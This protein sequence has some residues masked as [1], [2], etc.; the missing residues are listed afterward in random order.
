M[1]FLIP[2]MLRV[3]A[4]HNLFDATENGDE[5]TEQIMP[6]KPFFHLVES[7]GLVV[8]IQYFLTLFSCEST[9]VTKLTQEL[10]KHQHK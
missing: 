8:M 1:A 2:T 5:K 10:L 3:L 9:L 6:N 4:S 7:P